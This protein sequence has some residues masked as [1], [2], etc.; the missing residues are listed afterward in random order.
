MVHQ[1]ESETADLGM[2][3]GAGRTPSGLCTVT[4]IVY[5]R[6]QLHL[7]LL[8]AYPSCDAADPACREHYTQWESL[9][10]GSAREAVMK[11]TYYQLAASIAVAWYCAVKLEMATALLVA[12]LTEQLQSDAVPGRGD[13]KQKIKVD[14]CSRMGVDGAGAGAGGR[15]A[16]MPRSTRVQCAK[17]C[18][19]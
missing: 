17:L 9:S 15:S 10:P 5:K 16:C 8:K 11:N 2:N 1:I 4:C 3:G 13:A 6:A 12:L 14:L 7:T 18:Q 19:C